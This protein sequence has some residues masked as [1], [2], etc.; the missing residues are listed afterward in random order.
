VVLEKRIP[1]QSGLGGGSADAAALIRLAAAGH[2]RDELL[3][4]ALACGADVPFALQGGAA[5][6]TGIG[7]ELSLLP[8]LT[9][10]LFLIVVLA[11]ISTAQ[12]YAA[13]RPED[14]SD[15]ARTA[16]LASRVRARKRPD[17]SLYGSS[18]LPAALRVS[19][20]LKVGWSALRAATP[21]L[22]WAMTGSGGAFFAPLHEPSLAADVARAVT[23]AC[24]E[25]LIRAVL[26]ESEWPDPI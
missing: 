10:S 3:D 20:R 23:A 17:P 7:E 16:D 5:L 25:A 11:T 8:S 22:S 24:P 26:T 19:P 15:G 18:L 2:E 9:T 6:V 13:V 4:A 21:G 1:T 12:A 14:F